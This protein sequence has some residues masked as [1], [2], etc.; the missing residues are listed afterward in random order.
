MLKLVFQYMRHYQSQ[1]V[2][3]FASMVLTAA[4]MAGMG[5]LM[6]S[7]RMNDLENKKGIYGDWHY[8]IQAESI[9]PGKAGGQT[10]NKAGSQTPGK[11]YW[12][13]IKFASNADSRRQILP[14]MS[15]ATQQP[16]GAD[17][18][19]GTGNGSG[20]GKGFSLE[21]VGKVQIMDS[22]SV[23]YKIQFICADQSY[24]QMMHREF[25][26]GSYP[27]QA[28]EIATDRYVLR[29]LGFSGKVG[30]K[31]G[32]NGRLYKLSGIVK[33]RWDLDA[34][35]ME[36]FVTGAYTANA[37]EAGSR[38][39]YLKFA[40]SGALY[41][42][43]DAFLQAYGLPGS[44]VQANDEVT[45]FMG[46]EKP[47]SILDIVTFA[48]TNERGNFTYII[49]KL[50]SDYNL[51]YHGMLLLLGLFSLFV[52]YSIFQISVSRRTAE[53]AIMQTLGISGSVIAGTLVLELWILFLV[54][55]PVGCLLG[56][57]LLKLFYG[58][59]AGVFA[60][61]EAVPAYAAAQMLESGQEATLERG[62]HTGFYVS[63]NV[64]ALGFLFLLAALAGIGFLTVYTL[65]KQT[66]RQ[67]MSGYV[68]FSRC[69]Y[70]R[71]SFRLSYVLV[72]KFLF[73]NKKRAAGILLSLS[74]GGCMVLCTV[75]M[76]ENLKIHAEMSLKSDDGLG[77]AFRVSVKSDSL[78]DMVP[79]AVVDEIR[80]MPEL[81]ESYAVKFTMGELLIHKG[82]LTWGQYFDE[83]DQNSYHRQ[84]FG[85]ILNQ[86]ADGL[87]GVK[88]DV[89]GY[90]AGM[91]GQM[92]DFILEGAIVPEEMEKK[93]QVI[94]V[95]NRD[96][97]NNYDFYG[98]HPG[99]MVTLRVV[100]DLD[101]PPQ[102]LK[103]DSEPQ[104]YIEKEF[105][106]AA[107]ASRGLAQEQGWLNAGGWTDAQ[108]I[109]MTNSQ[110]EHTYGIHGYHF[111]HASP[112]EGMDV[113][114]AAGSLLAKI[115]DVPKAVLKDYTAAI[116]AQ[117]AYLERQQIFFTA[118]A[119]ILLAISLFHMINSMHYTILARKRE[120]GIIRAM[121]ITD[122]GLY[123]MTA[124][125]GVWYG[126]LTDIFIFLCYHLCLRRAMDYYMAHVVQFLHFSAQVPIGLMAGI[127][128][129]N[130]VVSVLAVF[131]PAYKI[132]HGAVTEEIAASH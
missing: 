122:I 67:A 23:P 76:V 93:G 19:A 107:V 31:V 129:F 66:I 130:I 99:D 45:Q 68:S 9:A 54:G 48:L 82:E 14:L 123:K 62:V 112:A 120:Y 4:L 63:W 11:L 60:N 61:G 103:F 117:E 32:I 83:M 92:Q 55:Y 43:L 80:Q 101:C 36:V 8:C 79:K 116:A 44:Q 125:A 85:G 26:Q 75:Y 105:E 128:G 15:I 50:Q 90:D 34:G 64:A 88:Y 97:Q 7:N 100:K 96:G 115:Q 77:S 2:A 1:T 35:Y 108:S 6:Y 89:Y 33:S 42:Q 109:I 102:D 18:D 37:L 52:V 106:V 132:V 91:L 121:G 10:P 12:R 84:R 110:M 94:V 28:D 40:E 127:L 111:L 47:D 70:S 87:Y 46:G 20:A 119:L 56:N 104:H 118:V 51:A 17:V 113:E 16:N 39:L 21:Q 98:K 22:V 49:L 126:V 86:K 3:I 24:M 69:I 72:R 59:L 71:R 29:N 73:S 58:R 27:K 57:G 81:S 5:S 74:I 95:A 131:G 114:A 124:A 53:Y 38:Y 25:L 30:D 65:H 13:A 41:K 78:A